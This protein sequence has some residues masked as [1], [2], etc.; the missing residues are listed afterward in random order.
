MT[1]QE[2][3]NQA[4][5]S[6]PSYAT[7][8]HTSICPNCSPNRKPH[9]QKLKCLG[10]K[11]DD[12]GATW[13]C[14]HCGWSG[15]QK[16]TG[17]SNGQGGE[18][19]AIYDYRDAE[20]VLRFQKVR[21]LP[22]SKT[23]F[24]MRRPDGPGKW[25]KDTKGVD[26]TLL[27]RIDE[28]KE[29]IALGRRIAVVEGEKDANNLWAIG[30]PATC[31][32]YG[33]SEPGKTPKWTKEHS[34]QLRGADIVV[35]NDNDPPG[36]A[37]ADV[38]CRLSFCVAERVC[39]LDL[40]LHWP[41][42]PEGADVSDWLDAGHRREELDALIKQA[43]DWTAQ[44][45]PDEDNRTIR[46]VNGQIARI[47]DEAEAALLAVADLVPIMVRAGKLVQPIVDKLP[48][49]HDRM[50]DVTL[51]KPLTNANII[52]LL[53][54]HAA[55]FERYNGRSKKW[56]AVD[57]PAN[58]ATQLL[59]KGQWR[60]PKVVG[61]ITAPTLRPDGSILDKPGYDPAT[62]LWYAPD[63]ALTMPPCKESPSREDAEQALA[64]FD[65]LLS[66][67]PFVTNVDRSVALASLLTSV[68]RGAFD[69]APMYLFRAHDVGSGKS[70]LAD[71]M[72][73]VA[74]GLPCPVITNS[75]SVEEMEKRLGA[76]LLEGVPMVSLDNCSCNIGGDLLCQMTERP[77]VRIRILGKS[78]APECEWRGVLFGTGNNITLAGDM[79]RRGLIA[80][81]DPKCERPELRTFGFNPIERVLDNRGAYIAA[82]IAIARAY[83]AAGSPPVC[84]T[85]LGSYER[86]SR[87][88]R[89][90][91]VWLEKEDPVKSMEEL[92]QED[93]E[94]RALHNLIELWRDNLALNMSYTARE[95]VFRANQL[96][97]PI[98]EDGEPEQE[99]QTDLRELLLQQA[100]TQRGDINTRALGNWLMSVQSRVYAG[101][102]IKLMK[103]SHSHGNK[104]AL[105]EVAKREN[106]A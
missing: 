40:A 68:L 94:R 101:M 69:V 51:L 18:F 78:E 82:A 104:Y 74:R 34:E 66:G 37:H 95:L 102:C 24:F 88:V 21:N 11:I 7:G 52:Y 14:N 26:T 70:F 92:R 25:I 41:N 97:N 86:W 17:K 50:T 12:Q 65:D 27:Y 79:T 72:S 96:A 9:H 43:P 28:V 87:I 99:P 47:V 58:V 44:P 30:I 57:P 61:V 83:I 22:G 100:G 42:M 105:V 2:L 75:K 106:A 54:K 5:I 45:E 33:A 29:A 62:Q 4:G 23:R 20:G 93:P 103:E 32:A 56:L 6:L 16:G 1:P 13:R 91:L 48:A 59:Q 36:Y 89:S 64:L 84:K 71:L 60:F 53:N 81:L 77:L 49:S 85:P 67:F 73:T 63:S 35:F 31:N 80:N 55:V 90:P 19:A 15:P 3:L 8:N 46:I 10:V 76:L 38:T 39:R 98:N